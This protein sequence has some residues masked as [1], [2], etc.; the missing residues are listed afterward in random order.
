MDSPPMEMAMML[1]LVGVVEGMDRKETV[2]LYRVKVVEEVNYRVWKEV[3]TNITRNKLLN[4]TREYRI[5][6]LMVPPTRE[7]VEPSYL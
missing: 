7:V 4:K 6:Q 1:V 3:N 2:T 5:D